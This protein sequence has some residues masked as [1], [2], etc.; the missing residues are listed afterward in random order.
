VARYTGPVCKLCRREGTKLFLKGSRCLSDK[1]AIERRNY[2]PGEHGR[3]RRRRPSDYSV[4]LREKQKV[5]RTYGVLERQFRKYF[6][7]AASQRGITGQALLV[8]L[9]SRLDNVVYR[10]GFGLSR[11]HARQLVKHGHIQING[12]RVDI[13]SYAIKPG[14]VVAIRDKSRTNTEIGIAI[15]MARSGGR[16]GWLE[17]DFDKLTG[18][19]ARLPMREDIDMEIQ[20]QLIVE[21]YSK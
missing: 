14:D 1:C 5:K 8:T 19:V 7:G 20:E 4:Q 15:D 3:A 16:V 13:P 18:T 9:E 2:P 21:L 17:V 12:G 10:M 6:K 11:P